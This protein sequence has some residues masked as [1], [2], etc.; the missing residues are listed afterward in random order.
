MDAVFV[1][2][3]HLGLGDDLQKRHPAT[4]TTSPA[5][6]GSNLHEAVEA[7]QMQ[8]G[9][10]SSKPFQ[11]HSDARSRKLPPA[12]FRCTASN[13]HLCAYAYICIP[14]VRKY[15]EIYSA[16]QSLIIN[17]RP[18]PCQNRGH[19]H[20]ATR[21]AHSRCGGVSSSNG[22]WAKTRSNRLDR[23][24]TVCCKAETGGLAPEGGPLIDRTNVHRAI[25]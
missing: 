11:T 16:A 5:L 13:Q 24:P 2:V 1:L 25:Y 23:Y 10:Q 17:H 14:C 15:R 4:E 21:Q 19:I 9:S 3:L 7:S 12:F 8:A 22:G 20:R 6:P 18:T